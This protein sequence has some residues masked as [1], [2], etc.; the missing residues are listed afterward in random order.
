MFSQLDDGIGE[1][2]S[3]L[4]V[5]EHERHVR[6]TDGAVQEQQQPV[7]VGLAAMLGPADWNELLDWQRETAWSLRTRIDACYE[8]DQRAERLVAVEAALAGLADP[9]APEAEELRDA[10]CYLVAALEEDQDEEEAEAH[11]AHLQAEHALYSQAIALAEVC[12]D[13]SRTQHQN[14][15]TFG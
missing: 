6:L 8:E 10:Y 3:M 15:L 1:E 11:L 2:L 9:N 7:S 12:L 5:A 13:M 4:L 14:S